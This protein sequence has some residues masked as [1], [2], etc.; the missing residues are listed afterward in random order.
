MIW[1]DDDISVTTKLP[2]LCAVD[3]CFQREGMPHTIA[4]IAEH[5]E[6]N[7]PLVQ[8]ILERGMHVQLHA[9][10]HEDLRTHAAARAALP[11]AVER[12]TQVFGTRP[13]VLYPPWNQSNA[14]VEAAASALGLTVSTQKVSLDQFLRCKGEVSEEV[15]NFHYWDEAE[16]ALLPD[17]LRLDRQRSRAMKTTDYCPRAAPFDAYLRGRRGLV[18][19]EVGVDAG[20]HAEALLRY[21][22]VAQLYLVD[23]WPKD[24]HYGFCEG[25]LSALGYRS[26]FTMIQR[27]S[28]FAVDGFQPGQLD[29]VYCDETRDAE[30]AIGNVTRWWPLLKSGGLFGYRGYG[31][32]DPLT[33]ALDAWVARQ[34]QTRRYVEPGELILVKP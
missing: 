28:A 25:R 11:L 5:I 29:F 2:P 34:P 7:R 18:G 32:G 4:V 30:T 10:I 24:F 23:R 15:I 31:S 21:C 12:L 17:A 8:A 9:W 13:T 20:A 1:R 16:L 26:R 3:D 14:A 33:Q 27:A 19:V 22:D 6:T